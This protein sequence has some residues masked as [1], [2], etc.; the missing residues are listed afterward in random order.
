M[1]VVAELQ[2]FP[3]APQAADDLDRYSTELVEAM[4][5][6]AGHHE[7]RVLITHSSEEL[8]EELEQKFPGLLHKPT[9][10]VSRIPFV[11]RSQSGNDWHHDAAQLIRE[12]ALGQVAPDVIL[13][14]SII[15]RSTIR[16]LNSRLRH[17]TVPCATILAGVPRMDCVGAAESAA[18]DGLP[19]SGD[20]TGQ[21]RPWQS[22]LVLTDSESHKQELLNA[23]GLAPEQVLV[24]PPGLDVY[25]SKASSDEQLRVVHRYRLMPQGFVL[26]IFRGSA[27]GLEQLLEAYS[28][29]PRELRRI[30][31]LVVILGV[32]RDEGWLRHVADS[33]GVDDE[34]VV[35]A[36]PTGDEIV[37][38]CESCKVLVLTNCDPLPAQ[39]ALS[40]MAAGVP[41][42][43]PE[44]PP[45]KELLGN[46]AALFESGCPA[47]LGRR[48]LE[49]L[50][51]AEP[52]QSWSVAAV[53]QARRFSWR[54][55]ARL[56]FEALEKLCSSKPKKPNQHTSAQ[57]RLRLAYVSP[58]PPERSG[59]A[60]YS[61]E[62]LPELARHYDI[63]LITD[64]ARIAD[65]VLER[66]F[67]RVSLKDFERIARSY[68][69]I[70]Y[71]IGNSPFHVQ[72]PSLL[73]RFPGT[74]V[75]HDFFLSH[76]FN[77]LQA[78]D[79]VSLW[80][81]LYLSHGYPALIAGAQKDAMAAVWAYPCNLAVLCNAAGIVVH[82]Q[83]A[84]EL[85]RQW[86]GIS[87]EDWH[88][89]PQLRKVPQSTT[90]AKARK[91]LGI[92][93]ETFL[94]CSFG[95]LSEAKLNDLL[96]WSWLGSSLSRRPDCILVFVGGDGTGKPYQANGLP[97]AQVR[98]TGY[99]TKAEY[100]LYLAAADVGV[101]LRS[102]LSRGETPRS[103]L[104]C[105]AYGVATIVST[106][107]AL[108]DLPDDSVLRISEKGRQEELIAALEKLYREPGLRAELGKRA[109][110]YISVRRRPALIAEHYVKAIEDSA[111]N[112]P[113]SLTNRIIL[114]AAK[115]VPTG[116]TPAQEL[117]TIASCLAEN[118]SVVTTPQLLVD[119]TILVMVGDY[120]TGIQ[121]VT[122]G[123][124]KYLLENPPA[125]WR[126]E[127]VFRRHRETYRYARTFVGKY[128]GLDSFN[129]EDAPVAVR[130]GDIFLG[131]DWDA[132]IAIDERAEHWL[133]HNRQ[134]G[135]RTVFTIYDL[136][137]LQHP[138]W[139]K[140][141]MP[142]VFHGWLSQLCRLA[143]GF[144]CISRSVADELMQWLDEYSA[145]A[146]RPLDVGYFK[147]GSDIEASWASQGL[148]SEDE[149]LLQTLKDREVFLMVGTVEPRKGHSQAL[150]ALERLWE[151]GEDAALVI[152]GH[153]GWMV[154]ALARRLRS[155]TELGRRLFWLEQASDEVLLRLYTSASALLMA[156]E[157]EGFGLPLAEAAR[158]GLPIIARDLAVFREVA[159]E[160]A[161]YFSGTDSMQ[162]AMALRRWLELYRRREH[163]KPAPPATWRESAQELLHIVLDGNA[164]KRWPG[165]NRLAH[166]RV[167]GS[168]L[169]FVPDSSR[170]DG[171]DEGPV[172]HSP[173]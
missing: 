129:P 125:G 37:A 127:P 143:D 92:S 114:D 36:D 56:S 67:R 142:S 48:L 107:P 30:H 7:V 60:D 104:D 55:S 120:R 40:A 105:M 73:E 145:L 96:F 133:L 27:G 91:Q 148:S 43:G 130:P 87:G 63:D 38:L 106:H 85:A 29:I 88:V 131:L 1:R 33:Y 141:D 109:R 44:L 160:H 164:Y 62:L 93:P 12:H 94:V 46:S 111:N 166:G 156:S 20:R 102:E 110:Q 64:L 173:A 3:L 108:V 138:E 159:G 165:K 2:V 58:L 122:R 22:E 134:R 54:E 158:H 149:K 31:R 21:R 101:Q 72:I 53:E 154:D 147:L 78:T 113:V 97:A 90:R 137:P 98:S 25:S 9:C 14:A 168:H 16:L 162:L 35:V 24:V 153:E 89:I 84:R 5:R 139:F 128:L 39:E 80:R 135:M 170:S 11:E 167:P 121:R 71:H 132:G 70:L 116:T 41:V 45:V 79:G 100:E 169:E 34:M 32:E 163:P 112:H 150:S 140:P 151:S 51:D 172:V 118:S 95:F 4:V 68:D 157:G 59:I 28:T 6:E 77:C 82:S 146:P 10:R 49:S 155:H 74:V 99:V 26:T 17:L 76:L 50:S 117:A 115:L 13:S 23:L 8:L 86:F 103:V 66:E 81:N 65:P 57:K 69:R 61:A 18:T 83:H 47:L 19:T 144:A 15:K 136:L 161:F 52:F 75:L 126:I 42:L 171:V 123:I 119:V 124:L 152:C